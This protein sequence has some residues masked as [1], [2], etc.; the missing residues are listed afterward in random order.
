M[1]AFIYELLLQLK[2]DLPKKKKKNELLLKL[3]TDL[4]E[5][6]ELLLQLKTDRVSFLKILNS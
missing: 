5:K 4:P 2:T 1:R 6:N 3:K